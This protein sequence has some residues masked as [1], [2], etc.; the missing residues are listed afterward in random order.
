MQDQMALKVWLRKPQDW[1]TG[2]QQVFGTPAPDCLCDLRLWSIWDSNTDLPPPGSQALLP[3]L[4]A[5]SEPLSFQSIAGDSPQDCLGRSRR[6][7]SFPS[8]LQDS[9]MGLVHVWR[10]LLTVWNESAAG[11]GSLQLS[12]TP[13]LPHQAWE[14][15]AM[16]CLLTCG[17]T[18]GPSSP[19]NWRCRTPEMTGSSLV[20]T[21]HYKSYRVQK[22]CEA[23]WKTLL[24]SRGI[25]STGAGFWFCSMCCLLSPC[26]CCFNATS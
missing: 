5:S 6:K 22:L 2:K 9:Q 23:G 19:G 14:Q 18:K 21:S 26:F 4:E 8:F 17:G 7:Y 20:L 15:A 11:N 1:Q 25:Q 10:G 16:S 3:S 12:G 24:I 13:Q